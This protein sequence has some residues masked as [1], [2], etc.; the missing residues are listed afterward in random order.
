MGKDELDKLLMTCTWGRYEAHF[1]ITW[2][3]HKV[4]L[5]KHGDGLDGVLVLDFDSD[6]DGVSQSSLHKRV[7]SLSFSGTE[8]SCSALLRKL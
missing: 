5:Q 7:H 8:K 2:K 3:L 4:V 1:G 6:L